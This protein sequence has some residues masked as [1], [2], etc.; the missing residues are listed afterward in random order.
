MAFLLTLLKIAK[1]GKSVCL[2]ELGTLL[3]QFDLEVLPNDIKHSLYPSDTK[4]SLRSTENKIE[5]MKEQYFTWLMKILR[6]SMK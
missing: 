4:H 2:L 1:L 5:E 3:I 6:K